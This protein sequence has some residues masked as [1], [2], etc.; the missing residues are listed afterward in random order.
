VIH[1]K[2][3]Y[4]NEAQDAECVSSAKVGGRMKKMDFARFIE[5]VDDRIAGTRGRKPNLHAF[6]IAVS[7]A[8]SLTNTLHHL[9]VEIKVLDDRKGLL[10]FSAG[11]KIEKEQRVFYMKQLND[12]G[13]VLIAEGDSKM[14]KRFLRILTKDNETLLCRLHLRSNQMRAL[15]SAFCKE[16]NLTEHHVTNFFAKREHEVSGRYSLPRATLG[17]WQKN[18]ETRFK[19]YEKLGAYLTSFNF[20]AY[21]KSD[22]YECRITRLGRVTLIKGRFQP[23]I[24]S[25]VSHTLDMGL[26]NLDFFRN[27]QRRIV[28]NKVVLKPV[29]Y[30]LDFKLRK[31]HFALLEKS[32]GNVAVYAMIH[33][34]NPYFLA[35]C[36]DRIDQ[37]VYRV[38]AYEDRIVIVPL[39]SATD[40]ALQKLYVSI[41]ESFVE[42]NPTEFNPGAE[43][44]WIPIQALNQ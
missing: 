13:W 19:D 21:N 33:S 36:Y 7:H 24:D 11:M 25:L 9:G 34:G 16:M 18:A 37:S 15:Y 38:A 40:T 23:F 4:K 39:D 12:E 27:R 41:E 35:T 31:N 8:E 44:S 10:F 28:D 6:C 26:S 14:G 29:E 43:K 20:R 2:I 42:G 3:I 5:S 32:I 30:R 17:I 22:N 1:N